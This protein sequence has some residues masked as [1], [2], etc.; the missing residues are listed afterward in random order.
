MYTKISHKTIL[1]LGKLQ[2]TKDKMSA[3]D[4][5]LLLIISV[6]SWGKEKNRNPCKKSVRQLADLSNSSETQIRRSL[7]RLIQLKY[8]KQVYRTKKNG[9]VRSTTNKI[10]GMKRRKKEKILRSYYIL[11]GSGIEVSI[12]LKST[13]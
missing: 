5:I 2:G 9:K 1:Q 10:K 8:I 4:H 13:Q 11:S 3:C 6:F 7:T 12:N